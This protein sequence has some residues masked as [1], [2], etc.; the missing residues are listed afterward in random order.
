MN[1]SISVVGSAPI[2][3]LPLAFQQRA[4]EELIEEDGLLVLGRGLGLQQI[5]VHM[6]RCYSDPR[7]LVLLLNVQSEELAIL[8]SHVPS[9]S[10]IVGE[11][12]AAERNRL[13]KQG[14]V[15]S[16]SS[17]IFILDLLTKRAP[18]HLITGIIIANAHRIGS[19]STEA[20]I[21]RMLR[22]EHDHAFIKAL[23]DSPE[24]IAAG[25]TGGPSQRNGF[26]PLEKLLKVL[27]LRHAY[28]WPRFRVEVSDVLDS[29]SHSSGSGGGGSNQ[30][31]DVVELRQPISESMKLAQSAAMECIQMCLA[32][33]RKVSRINDASELT[34]EN[35]LI[36]AFDDMLMAQLT[37]LWH[38]VGIKT[39]R[40]MDD[41]KLLRRIIASIGSLDCINL[42]EQMETIMAGNKLTFDTPAFKMVNALNLS[43]WL[44][45]D[46]GN[47]LYSVIKARVYKKRKQSE[48]INYA[49]QDRG[50]PQN[51]ALVLETQPKWRLL[52]DVIDEVRQTM[53]SHPVSATANPSGRNNSRK[54]KGKAKGGSA[55]SST[56][57]ADEDEKP[58]FPEFMVRN[59][60]NFFVWRGNVNK[61]Q[62][63]IPAYG[64]AA[65]TGTGH[66]QQSQSQG[67]GRCGPKRGNQPPNKRRRMRG[68]LSSSQSS[69]AQISGTVTELGP[70]S[71]SIELDA[72]AGL[73][74][75]S[76]A[77]STSATSTR[78]VTDAL[79]EDAE[80]LP[81]DI[82]ILTYYDSLVPLYLEIVQ[83][84][85]IIMYDPSPTFVR[86]VE[87]YKAMHPECSVRLYFM[88]YDNS[89][90]EQ[91]YLTTIRR[92]KDSFEKLIHEKSVMVIPIP[93]KRD[94]INSTTIS[95][96]AMN[97]SDE[98]LRTLNT[99]IAGGGA[100]SSTAA[101][102]MLSVTNEQPRI[103]VDTRDFRSA[104]PALLHMEGRF[105]VIPRTLRVGDYILTPD[106]CVERKSLPDLIA[107]LQSGHLYDQCTAMCRYY[108]TPVLLIEFDHRK[109]FGLRG[110]SEVIRGEISENDLTSRLCMLMLS[111]PQLR[112]LWSAMPSETVVLFEYLKRDKLEPEADEAAAIGMDDRSMTASLRSTG[113]STASSI[114]SMTGE[115]IVNIT[116]EEVLRS[117]P[118]VTNHNYQLLTS[119]F[120]DL[121]SLCDATEETLVEILGKENGEKLFKFIN[122]SNASKA[123]PA[124]L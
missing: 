3:R 96:D 116:P 104:L 62:Q 29:H 92:E 109:E 85:F 26:A 31:V 16:I 106:I 108:R 107:S 45:S 81:D 10:V 111:F 88:V 84:R 15:I 117:M 100:T 86:Q 38:R 79:L 50:L 68:G 75:S 78:M 1:E 122:T 105:Q 37:N 34:V 67:G 99:R 8:R 11:T 71:L 76:A 32:E 64:A 58:G 35:S 40:L 9:L 90:E 22:E 69:T 56:T 33:I 55:T 120:E 25:S 44:S 23:S 39:R 43:P 93:P 60:R 112:I 63:Y 6:L 74:P 4:F 77:A 36:S 103:I 42:L 54:G 41:I 82:D 5:L 91:Q 97:T 65:R 98:F 48:P 28:L 114:D 73:A 12:S 83:P 95:T 17:Q 59:L 87:V 121:R 118:G 101:S 14:G 27:H 53:R 47:V 102:R 18:T 30:S 80:M 51:I 124:F 46:A 24:A 57:A 123:T 20:F 7:V 2:G 19:D 61:L 119:R 89:V 113:G 72:Q 49:L 115:T 21:V 70:D 13:Y 52:R 66:Q 110:F 94:S